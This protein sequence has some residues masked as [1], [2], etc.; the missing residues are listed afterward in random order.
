[1]KEFSTLSVSIRT[2]VTE[3][4]SAGTWKTWKM[5]TGLFF[6]VPAPLYVWSSVLL[7]IGCRKSSFFCLICL[8]VSFALTHTLYTAHM[9]T[10]LQKYKCQGG[11]PSWCPQVM[12]TWHLSNLQ[13]KKAIINSFWQKQPFP[14][15]TI[16]YTTL[17]HIAIF[18]TLSACPALLCDGSKGCKVLAVSWHVACGHGKSCRFM[19]VAVWFCVA[20]EEEQAPTLLNLVV[21]F[22]S[23]CGMRLRLLPPLLWF[24][25]SLKIVCNINL[26]KCQFLQQLILFHGN[27]LNLTV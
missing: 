22:Y 27:V 14:W 23:I 8:L 15:R 5:R 16:R 17:N 13:L 26:Q 19:Y 24:D 3:W 20:P 12:C 1:M 9:T 10:H 4:V 2:N 21:S 7:S 18:C 11:S 6:H 25:F